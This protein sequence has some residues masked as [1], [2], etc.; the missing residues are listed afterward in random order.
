VFPFLPYA[1]W[2]TQFNAVEISILGPHPGFLGNSLLAFLLPCV[3]LHHKV[4][5]LSLRAFLLWFLAGTLALGFCVHIR[6]SIG[7]MGFLM[8][9]FVLGLQTFWKRKTLTFRY[10][11][12]MVALFIIIF[13]AYHSPKA[14]IWVRDHTLSMAPHPYQIQHGFAH[15]LYIGLGEFPNK[16]GIKLSDFDGFKEAKRLRPDLVHCSPEYNKFLLKRY[17]DRVL[18]DPLEILRIYKLK[19]V[20]LM[21]QKFRA[22]SPFGWPLIS[23]LIGMLAILYAG[24]R[25]SAHQDDPNPLYTQVFGLSLLTLGFITLFILQGI[26]ACISYKYARPI[27]IFI[28][29]FAAIWGEFIVQTPFGLRAIQKYQRII[30]NKD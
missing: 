21:Q 17:V 9:T 25:W 4:S 8:S 3:L 26:C 15:N 18:E 7:L 1:S 12:K 16:W 2:P 29:L 6:E 20:T 14:T 24:R 19:L 13:A 30:K 28:L 11:A 27:E 10:A 5:P 23:I 22:L